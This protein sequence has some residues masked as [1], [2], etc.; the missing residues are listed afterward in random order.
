[1]GKPGY[2]GNIKAPYKIWKA[3]SGKVGSREKSPRNRD[4]SPQ[5][6]FY[7]AYD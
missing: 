3:K 4:I 5:K 7:W 1:M 6:E 2:R